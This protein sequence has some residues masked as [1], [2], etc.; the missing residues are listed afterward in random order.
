MVL[1]GPAEE[2]GAAITA[3]PR[4]I[5]KSV[6]RE[7]FMMASKTDLEWLKRKGLCRVGIV[8]SSVCYSCE[9]KATKHGKLIYSSR[10][11]HVSLKGGA[12]PSECS[13]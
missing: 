3:V 6:M 10:L 2:T 11:P 13:V 8:L 5:A 1:T 7:V 12:L 4:L 9:R